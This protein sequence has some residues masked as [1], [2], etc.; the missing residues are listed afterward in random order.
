MREGEVRSRVRVKALRGD[1]TKGEALLWLSLRAG[2]RRGVRFR[3][4]HPIG[5]FIADFACLGAS[6]VVEIDGASHDF[7]D[8]SLRDARKAAFVAA[9]G[10]R[11]LR[12]REEDVLADLD[13][14]LRAIWA[15]VGEAGH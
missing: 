6:L 8:R 2:R 9:K 13:G 4:Q 7:P 3:R 11:I 10:F 5:P 12:L 15:A 1:L 14:A